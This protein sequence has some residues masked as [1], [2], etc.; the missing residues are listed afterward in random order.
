MIPTTPQAWNKNPRGYVRHQTF[1]VQLVKYLEAQGAEVQI[2]EDRNGP[3]GGVDLIVNGL[4]IDLK[5]FGL[6]A[7][8]KTL[9]WSSEYYRGR[10]APLYDNLMTDWFV[11]PTDGPPSEWIAAPR[12]SLRT[13]KFGYAPYYFQADAIT[14]AQFI[15]S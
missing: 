5:G 7:Y 3:D 14:M 13:S 9:T 6:D 10:R 8:G 12:S 11:H 1:L 4:K 2:P 15:M